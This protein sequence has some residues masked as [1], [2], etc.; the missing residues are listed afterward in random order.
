MFA[1]AV[2]VFREALEAALLIGII[3][4]ATRGLP[5]RG[6]W[7]GFGMAA[8]LILSLVVAG[9][10]DVIAQWADG[11]G[12][13]LF[14]V[15]VLGAAVLML[16]WHNIWMA[17]HGK[18]M[19]TAAKRVAHRVVSGS[20]ELSAIAIVIALAVL[21]EG[22]ETVLFLYGLASSDQLGS[23]A[24][25]SGAALGLLGGATAGGALYAGLLRIPL[26]WLFGVTGLLVLLLASGMAGQ[27][28]RLLMQGD[29]LSF[30][31]GALWDTSRFLSLDSPLG[32]LLHVMM[33]YEPRPSGMQVVFYAG[34]FCLILLGM[35]WSGRGG[36]RFKPA[37]AAAIRTA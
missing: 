22:S 25:L 34:T 14:N 8:G 20:A 6:R 30:A 9:L 19:A 13:E 33:G 11:A 35:I 18:E 26:R 27:I 28:A 7:I 12:Q 23:A 32:N 17:S 37:P 16:A 2:I 24:V 36:S 21:R 5:A 10:T 29:I 1:A 31:G 15:G 3:A 4:A